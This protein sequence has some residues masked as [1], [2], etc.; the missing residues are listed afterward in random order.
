MVNLCKLIEHKVGIHKERA[1]HIAEHQRD[2]EIRAK[3]IGVR[4]FMDKHLNTQNM[5]LYLYMYIHMY[6]GV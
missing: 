2:N 5:S 4:A 6:K 3:P 1:A